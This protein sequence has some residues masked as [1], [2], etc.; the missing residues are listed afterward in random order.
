ML[1]TST[2][3]IVSMVFLLKCRSLHFFRKCFSVP[4]LPATKEKAECPRV[5][6]LNGTTQFPLYSNLSPR[7]L[8]S[9][10]ITSGRWTSEVV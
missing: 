6:L 1:A 7:T 10:R 8:S 2:L 3:C 5:P 9:S 4:G